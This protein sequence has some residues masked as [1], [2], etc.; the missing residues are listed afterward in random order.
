MAV[1][2]GFKEYL[3]LRGEAAK[4]Q[5]VAGQQLVPPCFTAYASR[6]LFKADL[7]RIKAAIEIGEG[8]AALDIPVDDANPLKRMRTEEEEGE[9][10]SPGGGYDKVSKE[11]ESASGASV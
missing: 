2:E 10:E 5:S 4:E 9:S 11:S 1:N 8:L 3:A 7:Q 6:F